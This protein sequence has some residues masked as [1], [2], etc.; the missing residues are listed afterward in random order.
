MLHELLSTDFLPHG[1]C[2]FWNPS[3]VALH[4]ISDGVI[5]LA[6]YSIPVFLLVF[7][8]KKQDIPFHWIFLMFGAFI[9]ACGTTHAMEIWTLWYPAYW[10]SGL[11]KAG[12]AAI[13]LATT[14]ALV[15]LIPQVLALRS[16]AELEAANWALQAEIL[17]RKRTEQ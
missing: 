4:V 17:E 14:V 2:Y 8:Q 7:V 15:P 1:H 16:P 5:T 6:Y 12:T 13:S 10:L 11:V 3:L 9:L